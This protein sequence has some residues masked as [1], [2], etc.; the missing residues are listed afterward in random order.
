MSWFEVLVLVGWWAGGAP[1]EAVG[2]AA[3]Y[4][5]GRH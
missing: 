4:W 5:V 3:A 2:H 1:R